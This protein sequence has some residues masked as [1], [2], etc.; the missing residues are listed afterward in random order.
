MCYRKLIDKQCLL[1]S[2]PCMMTFPSIKSIVAASIKTEYQSS[3]T[4]LSVSH[5][6]VN[7]LNMQH[8]FINIQFR[9]RSIIL[10]V[11]TWVYSVIFILMMKLK[12]RKHSIKSIHYTLHCYNANI[13]SS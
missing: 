9:E 8:I 1:C 11:G 4:F 3:K 13:T 10:E 2:T 6:T 5:L 7:K 12:T